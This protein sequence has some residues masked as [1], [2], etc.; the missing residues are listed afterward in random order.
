M[1][2]FDAKR[3]SVLERIGRL[4]Q[5][6][7]RAKEYLETGEHAS[8]HR[9]RPLFIDKLKDGKELPPHKDWVRSVFLRRLERRL[10]YNQKLLER[11]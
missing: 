10:R 6:I 5:D 8:W 1:V 4:E 3:K 11:L 7:L 9:F 2:R